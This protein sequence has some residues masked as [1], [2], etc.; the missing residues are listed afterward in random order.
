MSQS[1]PMN[2]G[3]GTSSYANNS[4]MQGDGLSALK[5]V[6]KEAV[7]K[8][9]EIEK[10]ATF[11]IADLGCSVGPNTFYAMKAIIEAVQHKYKP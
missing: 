5:N 3:D 7:I 6:I 1:F 9:L 11:A 4:S 8:N 2:G 10:M